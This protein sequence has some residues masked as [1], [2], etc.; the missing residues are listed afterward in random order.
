[1]VY[2]RKEWNLTVPRQSWV[3]ETITVYFAMLF[4]RVL[5][6]VTRGRGN[7]HGKVIWL[8]LKS[9]PGR[10]HFLAVNHWLVLHSLKHFIQMTLTVLGVLPGVKRLFVWY[11]VWWLKSSTLLRWWH[12]CSHSILSTFDI[13][14][15]RKLLLLSQCCT[16]YM[17]VDFMCCRDMHFKKKTVLKI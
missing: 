8:L 10:K 17:R 12:F 2:F 1:M 13:C 14:L 9:R 16:E 6:T 5:M 4:E 11:T 15:M 3:S 7:K